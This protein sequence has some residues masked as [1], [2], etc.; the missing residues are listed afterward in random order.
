[1]VNAICNRN[2]SNFKWINTFQASNIESIL[3]RIG[4]ALMV[5]IDTTLRTKEVP[6]CHGVKLIEAQ[7]IFAFGNVDAIQRYR[8]DDCASPPTHRAIA[9]PQLGETIG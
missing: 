1:M 8:G 3:M 5:S 7:H 6:C 4:A 2:L 9:S